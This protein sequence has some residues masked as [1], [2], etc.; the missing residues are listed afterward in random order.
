MGIKF[1]QD[2]TLGLDSA[3]VISAD[4]AK[5]LVQTQSQLVEVGV[6]GKQVK[7]FTYEPVTNSM[8]GIDK[9]D[10]VGTE[11]AQELISQIKLDISK[12]ER[13]TNRAMDQIAR[14]IGQSQDTK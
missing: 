12:E 1:Y 9:L 5:Q 4:E 10:W 11:E 6:G 2:K 13:A 3:Q 7:W 14:N 8:E